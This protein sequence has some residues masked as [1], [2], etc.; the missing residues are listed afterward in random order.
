MAGVVAG[1]WNDPVLVLLLLLLVLGAEVVVDAGLVPGIHVRR[2]TGLLVFD[3]R[4]AVPE[5]VV[6]RDVDVTW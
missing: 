3:P 4:T 6:A 2:Q 5:V 1:D